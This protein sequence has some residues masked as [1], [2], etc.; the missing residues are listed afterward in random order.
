MGNAGN[1][2]ILLRHALHR[3]DDHENHI[4]T[5]HSRHGADDT[6]ALQ[7]FL[8]LVLP[9]ESR[10]VDENILF[11]VVHDLCIH[12]VPG[13]S[14]DVGD[15]HPVLAE[16]PVDDGRFP[17]V[18]LSHDGNAGTVIFLFIRRL[19]REIR[20]HR[21]EH[22]AE[23]QPGGRRYRNRVPDPQIVKLIYIRQIF[24]KAVHLVHCQDDRLPR[25][26]QHIR[27]FGVRIHEPLPH[28]REK[29]DHIRR[30]DSDLRLLSH[31]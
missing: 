15:N 5:L 19:L 22:I 13:R 18:R 28:I 8:N 24:F 4:C 23:S 7:L 29:D 27:H 14:R 26:P 16:K 12:R 3:V 31:L 17:H 1:L 9:S 30:V 21:V 20:G 25:S 11:P 2:C 6:V 10:C